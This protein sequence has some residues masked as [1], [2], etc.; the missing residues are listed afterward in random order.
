MHTDKQEKPGKK[1]GRAVIIILLVICI[2]VFCYAAYQIYGILSEW[3]EGNTSYKDVKKQYVADELSAQEAEI[4]FVDLQQDYPDAMSWIRIEGTRIDY[5]VAQ[6][7]DN[8]YYVNHL[9][10]GTR[11]K[12]GAI[13]A[14]Y[15]NNA[16]FTDKN[17]ILYGHHMKSGAMFAALVEYQDIE[18]WKEHPIVEIFLPGE[19]YIGEIYSAYITPADS[20]TFTVHFENDENFA[21]Y[22]E[23]TT[24]ES[25]I[26]TGIGVSAE[27]RI[28]TLSTCTYEYDNARFVVHAKLKPAE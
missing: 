23:M 22:L 3:N 26:D 6:G 8:Q 13:F 18:F 27:D 19:H 4:N 21:E 17:T 9:I 16:D 25:L 14:D 11:N 10:D 2:A 7:E 12:N 15:R 1:K 28:I 24:K 5:P 20:E